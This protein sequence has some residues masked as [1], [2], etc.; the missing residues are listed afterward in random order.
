MILCSKHI[1]G[2]IMKD[3]NKKDILNKVFLKLKPEN[4]DYYSIKHKRLWLNFLKNDNLNFTPDKLHQVLR[5]IV[6]E[7][8]PRGDKLFCLDRHY[9]FTVINK[10]AFRIEEALERFIIASNPDNEFFNQIPIGGKKE[11]IDFGIKENESR[12]VFIELKQ[13]SS[14]DSLSTP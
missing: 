5:E 14:N 3:V 11:S 1:K 4:D 10:K 9:N 2:G 7:E 13:W 12:F 8:P 6:R